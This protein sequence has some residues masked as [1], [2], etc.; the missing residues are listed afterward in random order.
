MLDSYYRAHNILIPTTSELRLGSDKKYVTGALTITPESGTYFDMAVLDFESLY[1]GVVD[2]YNLSYETI[3][4]GHEECLSN[5]VPG[6]DINVCLRRRGIFS[7]M[8]GALRDLRIHYYKPQ[9][10]TLKSG[11]E[12]FKMTKAANAI[13]KLVLVAS[14]GVT[15]RIHGLASPVLGEAITAYGREVLQSTFDLAKNEGLKP[16]YGDSVLKGTPITLRKDGLVMIRRIEDV[17]SGDEVLTESGWAIVRATIPKVVRKQM[18]RIST[19]TGVVTVT[20]DHSLVNATMQCVRPGDL[21][22]GDL[23][24]SI[25]WACLR[26]DWKSMSPEEAWLLGYFVADGTAKKYT[27]QKDYP[28]HPGRHQKKWFSRKVLENGWKHYQ[29]RASFDR[30]NRGLLERAQ[31]ALSNLGFESDIEAYSSNEIASGMVYRLRLKKPVTSGAF[32]RFLQCYTDDGMKTIPTDVLNADITSC[33]SFID[34]YLCGDGGQDKRTQIWE[35]TDTEL[36]SYGIMLLARK[37]G[38]RVRYMIYPGQRGKK[39]YLRRV[40]FIRNDNDPRLNPDDAIRKIED[41]GIKE[42]DVYDLETT[43]NHFECGGVLLH[44][45][46]SVFL[47]NPSEQQVGEFTRQVKDKYKLELAYDRRYSVCVLSG[48][49]KAY[50][51]ILPGGET[52]I[53]GL[54]VAKSNSPRFFL[55]TFQDC[56][57]IL[58]KGRMSPQEFEKAKL[59]TR[60]V[61]SNALSALRQ[62]RIPLADLEYRVELR[63]DPKMMTNARTLPQPYQAAVLVKESGQNVSRRQEVG[64]VKVHP[65]KHGGRTFTVKPTGQ[66]RPTEV[67]VDDY[68]RN[69][70]SSL[71]QTFK[72]MGIRIEASSVPSLS[73]F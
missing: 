43:N 34:G 64:F 68:V 36:V 5:K 73:E 1:P 51:G 11:T 72:P 13:L 30:Q 46:D 59:G 9:L 37:C 6:Q 45:T 57:A 20:E 39:P 47:D 3:Q 38:M 18:Y 53:K 31:T 16:K 62:G 58:A 63:E 50:F 55:K 33:R 65:F 21:K 28:T 44:N 22:I 67:N 7:A 32:D 61:V 27:W 10:K 70:I 48:A 19:F 24:G 66:A 54:T 69:L 17:T 26:R 23:M 60:A 52:E 41:L 12:E 35:S 14:Y 42:S 8:I 40:R 2:V 71:D 25:D 29:A 15:V 49:K 56:L 4:C